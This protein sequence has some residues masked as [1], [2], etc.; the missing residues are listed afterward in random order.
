[1]AMDLHLVAYSECTGYKLDIF[2][3]NGNVSA[4]L[5]SVDGIEI[6]E[7]AY[8]EL[9]NISV[10]LNQLMAIGEQNES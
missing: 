10:L 1:M 8:F 6:E 2:Q 7:L 9:G 5:S 3:K 4:S